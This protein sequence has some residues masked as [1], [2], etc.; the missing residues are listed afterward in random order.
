[1]H[2]FTQAIFVHAAIERR[3]TK[4]TIPM[5]HFNY[6]AAPHLDRFAHKGGL[7]A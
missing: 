1:M 4:D 6:A 3:K 7:R 2:F 5:S